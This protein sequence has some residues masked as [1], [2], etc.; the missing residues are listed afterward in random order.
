MSILILNQAHGTKSL[1]AIET[2]E[3]ESTLS[4]GPTE[5]ILIIATLK[6]TN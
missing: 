1:T 4:M 3:F 2:V 6:I 5:T